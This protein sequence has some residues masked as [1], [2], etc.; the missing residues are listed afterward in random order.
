MNLCRDEFFAANKAE[1]AKFYLADPSHPY[2]QS[3]RSSGAARWVETRQ[4]I[5][6][7]VDQ[8]GSFLDVGCANGLLLETLPDWLQDVTIQTY[9]VD[10]IGELV[11]LA[12]PGSRR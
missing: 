7:A 12:G 6:S 3:G 9:G 5:A 10:F 2:Q 8:D 4:C 1:L 11:T